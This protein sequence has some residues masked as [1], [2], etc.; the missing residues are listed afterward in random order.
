MR[1]KS[2]LPPIQLKR[3]H[4]ESVQEGTRFHLFF[5]GIVPVPS[6]SI[7]ASEVPVFSLLS[8]SPT[9]RDSSGAVIVPSS[10]CFDGFGDEYFAG[11]E[12]ISGAVFVTPSGPT[13]LTTVAINGVFDLI[14]G[15]HGPGTSESFALVLWR[16][17]F[18]GTVAL[19]FESHLW[20]LML[21]QGDGTAGPPFLIGG[22]A[23]AFPLL[24][25][26]GKYLSLC[27]DFATRNFGYFDDV[28]SD[29]HEAFPSCSFDFVDLGVCCLLS[30]VRWSFES[31]GWLF[32][33]LDV[34]V[35]PAVDWLHGFLS[36]VGALRNTAGGISL[37]H[38]FPA[39]AALSNPLHA[40]IRGVCPYVAWL[41]KM[42]C[43]LDVSSEDILLLLGL[44]LASW[45]GFKLFV[46][47]TLAGCSI[48]CFAVLLFSFWWNE[49]AASWL[50][51]IGCDNPWS[52]LLLFAAG[53]GNRGELSFFSPLLS[54]E[55]LDEDCPIINPVGIVVLIWSFRP[56][57][58]F[59]LD[60]LHYAL[61]V[62]AK[63]SFN[64]GEVL[65]PNAW[66]TVFISRWRVLDG[67]CPS[68][69]EVDIVVL[70]LVG[71]ALAAILWD[72]AETIPTMLS[73]LL[74]WIPSI[75]FISRWRVLDGGCPSLNK[76]DIVVLNLV[77]SALAAILWDPVET[78]P[79]MLSMLLPWIPSTWVHYP[80]WRMVTCSMPAVAWP[81]FWVSGWMSQSSTS[82]WNNF[83]WR[84]S[85]GWELM[86]AVHCCYVMIASVVPLQF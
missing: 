65:S 36:Y 63:D 38:C 28:S 44:C 85:F 7:Q 64:L 15:F 1:F 24:L 12:P 51:L 72:P 3:S 41:A 81:R 37:L 25:I 69:N 39:L 18:P 5:F 55:V 2:L 60:Y 20:I 61:F 50:L 53:A 49:S 75:W 11:E 70:N 23:V 9:I 58:A 6:P 10:S 32:L 40:S 4:E 30:F 46:Q 84:S 33:C 52:S 68:L 27:S 54:G 47:P 35:A 62:A 76:V 86:V 8:L 43:W 59:W 17:L 57:E 74:P 34:V 66:A 83:G 19:Y 13:V 77:G 48:G 16:G 14:A 42:L 71:S 26:M 73:I 45:G 31:L 29:H 78:I 21:M 80:S 56:A 79:T 67:G 82:C 22:Q